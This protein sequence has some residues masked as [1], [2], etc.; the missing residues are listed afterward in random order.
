MPLARVRA[1][2]DRLREGGQVADL[3]EGAP[4]YVVYQAVPTAGSTV[5]LDPMTDVIVPVPPGYPAAQIDLAGLPVN[6]ALLPRL[7]GG[8]NN[9]GIVQV[10]G[11]QWQLASYHPHNGGGGPPWNPIRHGFHTYFDH[12]IAWLAVIS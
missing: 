4:S 5:G 1:E 8:Q 11:R 3:V 12:L 7:R 9:Q 2:L 10:A 6:S